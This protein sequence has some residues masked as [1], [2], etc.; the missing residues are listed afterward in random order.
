MMAA[1][2]GENV[3]SDGLQDIRNIFWAH[4]PPGSIEHKTQALSGGQQC[5][6]CRIRVCR[7]ID[8][9]ALLAVR[10]SEGETLEQG[11]RDILGHLRQ[12][13]VEGCFGEELS[14]DRHFRSPHL[15]KREQLAEAGQCH[16]CDGFPVSFTLFNSHLDTLNHGFGVGRIGEMKERL[17][18]S[19]IV[20][21]RSDGHLCLTRN[22]GQ[23]RG[24]RAFLG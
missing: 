3:C 22:T 6:C 15:I 14:V 19:E 9:A 12:V 4:D 11:V 2:S 13:R 7:G 8:L 5:S 21:D 18:V 17:P 16:R 10:D 23:A 20:L 1:R 24:G